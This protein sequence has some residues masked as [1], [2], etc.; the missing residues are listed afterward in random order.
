MLRRLIVMS[1]GFALAAAAGAVFLPI[2]VLFDPTTRDAGLVVTM[3]GLF[4]VVDE[5]LRDGA[6]EQAIFALGFV[7]WAVVIA[8]CVAP[9]AVAA[10]IGEVAGVRNVVWYAGA[11]AFLAAASP[12]IARAARKLERAHE[13]SAIEGRL[14]LL[15]FLT[16]TLT[17]SI[18]WFIAVRDGRVERRN[19]PLTPPRANAG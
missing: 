9:L 11:S 13:M 7:L 19:P 1:F 8:V 3:S 6:P 5:A 2:A 14:A 4:A 16:G 12:W 10:L 15:F 18:Y 17:G